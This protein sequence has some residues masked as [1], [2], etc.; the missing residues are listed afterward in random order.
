MSNIDCRQKIVPRPIPLKPQPNKCLPKPSPQNGRAAQGDEGKSRSMA[1][2]AV[3]DGITDNYVSNLIHLAWL[4][5]DLV[6]RVLD[7][8]RRRL[9]WRGSRCSLAN[10][11][12]YGIDNNP[13]GR[14]TDRPAA[15]T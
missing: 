12:F 9:R 10:P 8:I 15:Q 13:T 7:V 1:E 2:I 11:T 3:R 14:Q 5:P 6:S 4:S